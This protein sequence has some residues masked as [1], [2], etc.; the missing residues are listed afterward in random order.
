[1][2]NG[3]GLAVQRNVF[4]L[5]S[6]GEVG[7][8]RF[9]RGFRRNG[10]LPGLGARDD[11]GGLLAG[12]VDGDVGG[13]M[14]AEADALRAAKGAR[15]DNEDLLA[16][17]VH[18][19]AEAGKVHCRPLLQQSPLEFPVRICLAIELNWVI[20]ALRFFGDE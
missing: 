2:G 8:G 5:V 14:G 4:A 13:A 12:V 9:G 18:S 20:R 6:L 7:D 15:L 17:G 19:N 3:Q 1:M 16:G 10:R 11:V